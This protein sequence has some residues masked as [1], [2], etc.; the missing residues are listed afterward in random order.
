MKRDKYLKVS[1]TLD[2]TLYL[3]APKGEARGPG[4]PRPA[5]GD[6]RRGSGAAKPGV[7]AAVGPAG[8]C[9][10]ERL[11]AR[12]GLR[13]AEGDAAEAPQPPLPAPGVSRP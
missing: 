2:I 7:Q 11:R 4:S 3:R 13:T 12:R 6:G 1:G 9:F 10:Q 5:A 8:A